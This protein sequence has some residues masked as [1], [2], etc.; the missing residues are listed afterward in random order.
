MSSLLLSSFLTHSSFCF[1]SCLHLLSPFLYSS[2]CSRHGK[3][4]STAMEISEVFLYYFNRNCEKK[5]LD[6]WLEYS[7]GFELRR[8]WIYFNILH[9]ILRKLNMAAQ[10]N[11]SKET[12][13][14]NFLPELA[15]S[16]LSSPQAWSHHHHERALYMQ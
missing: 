1:L 11:V 5:G 14:R 8:P 13:G 12:T 6:F 10:Q 16:G 4:Q 15:N 3:A 7:A 9:K 2:L